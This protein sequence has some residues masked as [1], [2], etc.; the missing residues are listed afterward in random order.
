MSPTDATGAGPEGPGDVLEPEDRARRGT[1]LLTVRGL[2]KTFGDNHVLRGIDLEVRRG[3][4]TALIGPSGSG[5]TT[6]LRSLNGLAMPDAGTIT[7][8]P[9]RRQVRRGVPDAES[10]AGEPLT[11]DFSRKI[12][13]QQRFALRDRSAMVFQQH[14]LFPH[15]TVLQNVIEGPVQVQRVPRAEA[16]WR[17][18]ELLE[19][20][21]LAEKR[22]AYPHEL[23]GG[24]QQRVGIV[25]ALALRP[26][27]LLFDEPTSALD[28]ELVGEVL[29][30]MKE[31][32]DEGWTMVVVTH[33]LQFARAVAD[34][35]LF[36]D[37]GVVVERGNPERM[38]REPRRERT[39]QF[40]HRL[41]HPME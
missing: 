30:V 41:L 34:E 9:S 31:L 3:S 21:G 12:T 25:R 5:K 15:R 13:K 17:A 28:P 38:F 23:S 24:Q 1:P 16:T 6:V 27:L 8:A 37:G 14:N 20:V 36:L 29:A 11:L 40:L 10:P 26:E 7:A 39:R 32:A 18:T 2:H 4:V 33:E 22:D 35:V 19:R